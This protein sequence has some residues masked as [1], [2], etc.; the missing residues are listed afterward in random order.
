[1]ESLGV[2]DEFANIEDIDAVGE[3]DD[4]DGDLTCGVDMC[5]QAGTVWASRERLEKHR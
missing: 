3:T 1:M 2:A 5:P 4:G